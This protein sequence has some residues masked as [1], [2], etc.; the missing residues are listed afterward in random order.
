MKIDD[1]ILDKIDIFM[2]K[3]IISI[4]DPNKVFW[5]ISVSGGKDSYAMALALFLWYKKNNYIFNGEGIFINQWSKDEIYYYL[6]KKIDWMPVRIIDAVNETSVYT[7][8]KIGMQAPCSRCSQVR[9][10]IGDAYIMQYYRNGYY[11]VLAR[12]LHLTDMAISYL[13]RNFWGIDTIV[14]AEKLEKGK[15]FEKLNLKKE[16][17]LAKPLCLVREYECEQFSNYHQYKAICCG[18]PACAFPSRRDIVEESLRQLL[19]DALWEFSIN[20]ISVYLDRIDVGSNN[21]KEC[22]LQG[23]ESKH[24]H[25]SF[26]FIEYALKYWKSCIKRI[27]TKFDTN[28]YLDDIGYNYLVNN[29]YCLSDKIYMPK[30]FSDI[31]LSKKEKIMVATVGPFWGAIGYSDTQKRDSILQLQYDICN[32]K[33]DKLWSQVNSILNSYYKAK[34]KGDEKNEK[35]EKNYFDSI[36]NCYYFSNNNGSFSNL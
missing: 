5:W 7:N 36:C 21:I 29:V 3:N 24:P 1:I 20:G 27:N 14:F 22:S 8:Y 2:K 19:D 18:C 23:E 26:D 35:D 13:W 15:P 33:I 17:Y 12:G 34:R 4:M 11:N 28:N 30:F 32:I 25:L 9:K 31:E 16:I 6:C 10:D